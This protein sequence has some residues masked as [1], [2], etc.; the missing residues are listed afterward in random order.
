M[1]LTII[2]H[3]LNCINDPYK[4]NEVGMRTLQVGNICGIPQVLAGKFHQDNISFPENFSILARMKK[5]WCLLHE[6]PK[7]DVVHFHY[8]TGMPFGTDLII[9]KLLGKKIIMHYHGRI[10]KH[11]VPILHTI[12][13]DRAF[14]VTPDLLRQ[15]PHATWIPNPINLV[16]YPYVGITP[17]DGPIKIVHCP[18]NRAIKGTKYIIQA[19]DEL[20]NEG[21]KIDLQIIEGQTHDYVIE[22]MKMSDVVIDQL[23]C[24]WYGMVSIEAMAL[25]KPVISNID[26]DIDI[27]LE[28]F[29]PILPGDRVTLKDSIRELINF[30]DAITRRSK[31]GRYYV[32]KYHD[33]RRLNEKHFI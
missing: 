6:I 17:H 31:R 24:P 10:R 25:G 32:E 9:W 2:W 29:P 16:N 26:F 22:K 12:L 21:Y 18:S 4:K 23:N 15:A 3:W 27:P 8:S 30:P 1:A 20:R 13:V 33:I 14:V 28:M 5:M 11:G 19:I 7:Y